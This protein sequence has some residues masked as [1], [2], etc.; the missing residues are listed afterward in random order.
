MPAIELTPSRLWYAG[1]EVHQSCFDCEH[2]GALPVKKLAMVA[3]TAKQPLPDL[4]ER[5]LL[6]CGGCGS[7]RILLTSVDTN[8][9]SGNAL[10]YRFPYRVGLRVASDTVSLEVSNK[11]VYIPYGLDGKHSGNRAGWT[12][13]KAL[14]ERIDALP[15][16]AS[17]NLASDTW[18]G[19]RAFSRLIK[20]LNARREL[21]THG[22]AWESSAYED[23]FLSYGYVDIGAYPLSSASFASV[24]RYAESIYQRL[25]DSA[26]DGTRYL[27]KVKLAI[28][29]YRPVFVLDVEA[30]AVGAD[31]RC[32]FLRWEDAVDLLSTSL[33]ASLENV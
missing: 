6:H 15:E 7:S 13:L 1:Q 23:S 3:G 24:L 4:M 17:A 22:C 28:Y 16:T 19:S 10:L 11:S 8:S 32:A 29:E 25:D 30:V 21:A 27:L 9:D 5:G 12:D 14:P 26:I 20:D 18:G 31:E 33:V 2:L